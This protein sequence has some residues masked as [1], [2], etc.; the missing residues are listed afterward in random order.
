MVP[1]P[2]PARRWAPF[3]LI[4]RIG[5]VVVAVIYLAVARASHHDPFPP[6]AQIP[7]AISGW[8]ALLAAFVS[9]MISLRDE[10][11]HRIRSRRPPPRR[12]QQAQLP[13]GRS[14][15]YLPGFRASFGAAIGRL[16]VWLAAALFMVVV[17]VTVA[18]LA[19]ASSPDSCV[20]AATCTKVDGWAVRNGGYYR[21]YPYNSQGRADEQAPWVR[22]S[23]SAYIAET[24]TLDRSAMIFGL[25]SLTMAMLV[26]IL[27][28]GSAQ[29]LLGRQRERAAALAGGSVPW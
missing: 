26:S 15:D 10:Q 25:L 13:Y 5:L 8:L 27:I 24:G 20:S 4:V 21:Q 9:G 17:I 7:L 28:E 19:P 29:V 22:I 18:N 1:V 6:D 12:R 3:R 16:D 11:G 2:P 23:R 14:P